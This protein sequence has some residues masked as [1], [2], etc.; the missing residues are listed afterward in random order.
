MLN[1]HNLHRLQR[2]TWLAERTI[3]NEQH[4]NATKPK[5]NAAEGYQGPVSF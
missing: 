3:K 4:N 1:W 5:N 2:V